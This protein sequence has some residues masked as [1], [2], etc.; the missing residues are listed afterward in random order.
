MLKKSILFILFVFILYNTG[1]SQEIKKPAL[2]ELVALTLKNNPEIKTLKELIE[3]KKA[4][5][6]YSW[7]PDDPIIASENEEIPS[8]S[9]INKA[10]VKKYGIVQTIEFPYKYML[11]YKLSDYNLKSLTER[12]KI[13]INEVIFEASS[14]YYTIEMLNLKI[15]NMEKNLELLNDFYNKAQTKY[16]V[17]EV[18]YLE[19]LKSK[20]ELQKGKTGMEHLKNQ[21]KIEY[22]KLRYYIYSEE[23]YG[24][25]IN[26]E[27]NYTT[28][29]IDIGRIKNE[30]MSDHPLINEAEYNLNAAGVDRSLTKWEVLPDISIGY[31]RQ[32][33]ANEKFWIFKAEVSIPIWFF[34]KNRNKINE[35]KYEYKSKKTVLENVKRK[36]DLEV[37]EAYSNL[38]TSEKM[39]DFYKEGVIKEAEEIYSKALKGYE[40]GEYGYLDLL[41]AQRTL[42]S[43]RNE[44][45]QILFDCQITKLK[46][47]KAVNMLKEN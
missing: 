19:L 11:K 6:A 29:N 36:L 1:F 31:L 12:L 7:L 16:D 34:F 44:Y 18:P 43:T 2:S 40:E 25:E 41:E 4:A 27:I 23:S 39:V 3:S 14:T 46:L 13:V 22:E 21:L 5:K 32:K 45:A 47:Y 20:V 30:T 8:G 35:K 15:S 33:I 28:G 17:G 42:L 37:T 24:Y 9:A 26:T 10:G 38:Q